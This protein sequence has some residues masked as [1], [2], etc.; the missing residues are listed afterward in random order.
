MVKLLLDVGIVLGICC[1]G[2]LISC[3]GIMSYRG[4]PLALA[5]T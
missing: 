1:K 3:V 4:N 5:L 2:S